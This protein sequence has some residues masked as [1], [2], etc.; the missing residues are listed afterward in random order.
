VGGQDHPVKTPSGRELLDD[1]EGAQSQGVD[2]G[3][4]EAANGFAG[5]GDQWFAE[6]V[7]GGV[8][9]DW[10]WG[11]LTEFVKEAPEAGVGVFFDRVDA[12]FAAVEG[13]LF[14]AGNLIPECAEGGQEAAVGRA[15]EEFGGALGG[16]R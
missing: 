2:A 12:D 6:Q 14:E 5:I 9:E 1:E 4:V 3:A 15:I 16:D 7:E 8:D 10:G 13:E 11:G